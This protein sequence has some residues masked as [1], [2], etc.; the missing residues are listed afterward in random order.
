MAISCNLVAT[1]DF[2]S[3]TVDRQYAI[4]GIT[5]QDW[6][7]TTT[8]RPT[9]DTTSKGA[10]LLASTATATGV[11]TTFTPHLTTC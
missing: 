1:C 9:T 3:C 10:F 2:T 11:S 5:E 8:T 7:I 4:I 6:S